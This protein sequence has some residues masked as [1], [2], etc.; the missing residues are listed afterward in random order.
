MTSIRKQAKRRRERATAH[1]ADP[2]RAE[3]ERPIELERAVA[4]AERILDPRADVRWNV[5][6][7]TTKRP[8]QFDV[9]VRSGP[10]G[11]EFT[12]VFEVQGR[13]R[14]V[15]VPA[16]E[17]WIPKLA[18][19]GADRLTCVS[20]AGF[21]REV[22][23][24]AA[25]LN[26]RARLITFSADASAPWPV[27]MGFVELVGFHAT[28]QAAM[29]IHAGRPSLILQGRTEPLT[30]E[31]LVWLRSFD[32]GLQMHVKPP[33]TG[34]R[35]I[36]ALARGPN[37]L[38]FIPEMGGAEIKQL[39][40]VFSIVGFTAEDCVVSNA[41]YRSGSDQPMLWATH[42]RVSAWGETAEVT[43]ATMKDELGKY[44][45]RQR[46]SSKLD[47]NLVTRLLPTLD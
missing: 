22:R 8:R 21:T 13:N 44:S 26:S 35:I 28:E 37:K 16:F 40:V 38:H 25:A 46:I 19:S 1:W 4:N 39:N 7:P 10:A 30:L 5:M 12:T 20:E 31:D 34:P 42:A 41:S 33:P 23:N 47:G 45:I 24:D 18:S 9:V 43:L 27:G 17:S 36:M 29:T 11:R 14:P 15:S 32:Q 3:R 6:L 2:I